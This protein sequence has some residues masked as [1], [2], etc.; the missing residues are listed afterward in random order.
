MP[1]IV[2][3]RRLINF[4]KHATGLPDGLP[5][6]LPAWFTGCLLW[7]VLLACNAPLLAQQKNWYFIEKN[8]S[9]DS[10]AAI[11]FANS[12]EPVI[13]SEWLHAWSARGPLQSLPAADS[14]RVVTPITI[15]SSLAGEKLGFALEQIEAGALVR[16]GL[17]GKGVKVGI[18]DGGFLDANSS[19]ALAELIANNQLKAFRNFLQEGDTDPFAGSH[20]MD[21]EH[22]T[23]V[24]ELTGGFHPQ[25]NIRFGLATGAGY[26]LARTDHGAREE[27]QEEDFL[28]AAIEWLFAQDVKLVNV[29]LGYNTDF[30]NPDENYIQAMMD[31][32]T[33][34][35]TL[36]CQMAS[37]KGMLIVAAA[38][39]DGSNSWEIISAPA[40]AP[41]V[42]TVGATDLKYWKKMPFSS[43][44]PSFLYTTKPEV[45]CFASAGTSFSAPVITGLAACIWEKQ[46]A[47]SGAE[48]KSLILES[49]HLAAA[50]N[51]FVGYGVPD[52]SYIL[53]KLARGEKGNVPKLATP[54]K[55]KK[56]ARLV[57]PDIGPG[58]VVLFHKKDRLHTL[59]QEFFT[60]ES[61]Q[62]T[63][64]PA[65][66][67]A[68]T[69]VVV[70][71]EFL[72]EI[73]W[74]N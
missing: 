7:L 69:T 61:V 51:N 8:V 63:I 15:K 19:N 40:D 26:Y 59:E 11:L 9:K 47:L 49:S 31:G 10:A 36:A 37:E 6:G 3:Q 38:G 29:S 17:T 1:K 34:V 55:K 71:H 64:K 14:T 74:V 56:V 42:L 58:H 52:C 45:S 12:L 16:A 65:K 20:A 66:G 50:P 67:A 21:D 13:W 28:I 70:N 25:K 68:F 54:V 39:N 72:M 73:E 60:T 44:G 48:I 22:G 41:G 24:W 35:V 62:L 2:F 32:K 30:D 23:E 5:A 57:C 53:S 33:T 43:T 18:I 46:P 27:R 4:E